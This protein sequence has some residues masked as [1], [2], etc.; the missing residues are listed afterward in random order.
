MEGDE[1]VAMRDAIPTVPDLIGPEFS[2]HE[3]LIQ[4]LSLLE[5]LLLNQKQN[6]WHVASCF[7]RSSHVKLGYCRYNF[8]R[9]HQSI[10]EL[11]DDG[12]V[13]TKRTVDSEYINNFN[14]ILRIVRSNHD[15]RF[16]ISSAHE[17]YYVLKYDVQI[18]NSIDNIATLTLSA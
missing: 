6:W 10:S 3:Q 13:Q 14:P 15:V 11:P 9:V 5:L 2:A 12:I 16:L 8:Q 4:K 18:H 17:I 1:L 7:K